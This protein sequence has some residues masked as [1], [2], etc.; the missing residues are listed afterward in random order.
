VF[1]PLPAGEQVAEDD[2]IVVRQTEVQQYD[3][4]VLSVEERIEDKQE[5]CVD[6]ESTYVKKLSLDYSD[7]EAYLLAKLAYGEAGGEDLEGQA[8]VIRVVLNRVMSPNFPNTISEVVYQCEPDI[9]FAATAASYWDT[10]EPSERTWEA[11]QLVE[12]GWDESQGA[13]YFCAGGESQWHNDHLEELFVHGGHVFY[14]E[15]QQ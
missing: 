8:L 7:E 10:C 11:L 6:Y 2:Y 4:N 1:R 14:K 15:L 9:Q 5:Q 13:T 3:A 12:N